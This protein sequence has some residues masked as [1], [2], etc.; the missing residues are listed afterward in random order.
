MMASSDSFS[1]VVQLLL[2]AGANVNEKDNVFA[3]IL[4]ISSRIQSHVF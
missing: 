3:Y 1:D 4:K 2:N